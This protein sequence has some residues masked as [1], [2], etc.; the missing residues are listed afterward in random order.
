MK[1]TQAQVNAIYE[2][3]VST[4]EYDFTPKLGMELRMIKNELEKT[5]RA[6][7]ATYNDLVKKYSGKFR[8]DVIDFGSPKKR[9]EFLKEQNEL[10]SMDREFNIKEVPEEFI[11]EQEKLPGKFIYNLDPIIK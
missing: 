9:D 7:Q 2:T 11:M 8:E 4:Q 3:I 5:Y 1:L 6:Y 10:L